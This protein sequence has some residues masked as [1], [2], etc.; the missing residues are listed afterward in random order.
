MSNSQSSIAVQCER[1]D[2]IED[3][4]K[5]QLELPGVQNMR[6]SSQFSESGVPSRK[7]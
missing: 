5:V 3:K 6:T 2:E 1:E 7:D 4:K